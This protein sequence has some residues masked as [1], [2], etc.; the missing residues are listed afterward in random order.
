MVGDRP[1]MAYMDARDL[2]ARLDWCD[3]CVLVLPCGRSAHLELGY[4]AGAGKQSFV[5]LSPDNFEPELMYL[6]NTALVTSLEELGA[7]LDQFAQA[8]A[9]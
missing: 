8:E 7:T 5:L 6:L 3:T 9:A 4:A 2:R 1:V